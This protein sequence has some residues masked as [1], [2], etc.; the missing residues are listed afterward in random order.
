MHH[1]HHRIALRAPA[2]IAP[3]ISSDNPQQSIL[4]ALNRLVM[5]TARL[6][7]PWLV[8]TP[9]S[10]SFTYTSGI[11]MPAMDAAFHTIVQFTVPNGRNGALYQIANP[12]SGVFQNNSGDLIWQIRR[13][14]GASEIAAERNYENIQAVLGLMESPSRIAVIRIFENDVISLVVQNVNLPP[15]GQ[16]LSGRLGGHFYPKTWDDEYEQSQQNQN[17]SW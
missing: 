10:E 11:T 5:T 6:A 17:T 12:V 2:S 9:D 4:D 1:G 15:G 13:N 7:A 8:F 16:N 14:S 3:V